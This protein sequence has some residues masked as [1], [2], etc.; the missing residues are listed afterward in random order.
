MIP[1]PAKKSEWAGV[2]MGEWERKEGERMDERILRAHLG[3][4]G[5]WAQSNFT[6]ASRV[7]GTL[8]GYVTFYLAKFKFKRFA[9]FLKEVSLGW[10]WFSCSLCFKRCISTW[11]GQ[12]RGCER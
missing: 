12:E 1:T 7:A 2:G 3:P 11:V 4:L 6:S 5:S 9:S 8:A 10:V